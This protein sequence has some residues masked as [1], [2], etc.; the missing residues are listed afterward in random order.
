[1]ANSLGWV[2]ACE[3]AWWLDP[4]VQ[5]T[6]VQRRKLVVTPLMRMDRGNC[7]EFPSFVSGW[8]LGGG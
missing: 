8:Q 6:S 2:V 1:M 4:V 3:R 7:S 5:R